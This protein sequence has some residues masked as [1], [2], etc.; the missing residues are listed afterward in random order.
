M[1]KKLLS[2]LFLLLTSTS[3]ASSDLISKVLIK[4]EGKEEIYQTT[5]EDLYNKKIYLNY[6]IFNK[7]ADKIENNIVIKQL[8]KNLY[9]YLLIDKQ[10]YYIKDNVGFGL[11]LTGVASNIENNQILLKGQF[12]INNTESIESDGDGTNY[13]FKVNKIDGK[14][15]VIEQVLNKNKET[16]IFEDSEVKITVLVR[17]L[18]SFSEK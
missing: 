2:V 8:D 11:F 13:S 1:K 6:K 16:T 15:I 9:M 18:T 10:S 17:D 7:K 4:L 5:K 12:I 14:E 3:F